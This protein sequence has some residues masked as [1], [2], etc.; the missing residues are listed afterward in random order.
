V[1]YVFDTSAYSQLVR[2]QPDMARLVVAAEEILVPY[3]C[4]AE[5]RYG[6]ALGGRQA[7]NEKLLARFLASPK[8]HTLLADNLTT[9]YY[10]ELA[11]YVHGHGKQL[12]HHDIWIAA[13]AV[14]TKA[15]LVTFD[16]D[17]QHV[18]KRRPNVLLLQS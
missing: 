4:I 2:G 17:F 7:E 13:L 9:D 8:V 1:K 3:V 15:A 14:Q 5:L 10:V 16:H 12:S 11:S 18:P 6:F